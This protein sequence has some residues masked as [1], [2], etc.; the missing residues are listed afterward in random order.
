MEAELGLTA[1][2]LGNKLGNGVAGNAAG[3]AAIEDR[4][5]QRAL[6]GGER[7]AKEVFWCHCHF[8][9]FGMERWEKYN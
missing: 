7:T 5:A 2:T 8:L 1:T 4:T 3:E 9:E 6:L